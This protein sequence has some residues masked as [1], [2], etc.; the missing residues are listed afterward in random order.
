MKGEAC[1][2]FRNVVASFLDVEQYEDCY[3]SVKSYYDIV[4]RLPR[5]IV[6]VSEG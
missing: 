6:T 3:V 5:H 4:R 2:R 1:R